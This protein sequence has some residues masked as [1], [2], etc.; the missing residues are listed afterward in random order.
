MPIRCM[1]IAVLF[2]TA[3]PGGNAS[4]QKLIPKPRPYDNL[5]APNDRNFV[6]EGQGWDGPGRGAADLNYFFINGNNDPL[7]PGTLEEEVVVQAMETTLILTRNEH[8]SSLEEPPIERVVIAGVKATGRSREN[9]ELHSKV[10]EHEL[11]LDL[12]GNV[13]YVRRGQ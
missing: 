2:C 11:A 9:L 7:F 1:L 4:A 6:T 5:N 10:S 8:Q 3:C 12:L 13:E